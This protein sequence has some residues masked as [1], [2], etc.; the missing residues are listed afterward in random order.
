MLFVFLI[1]FS[2]KAVSSQE[3]FD[4]SLIAN[5]GNWC[6]L[7]HGGHDDC[8]N[9]GPCS[10]CSEENITPTHLCLEQCPPTDKLDLLCAIH[11]TCVAHFGFDTHCSY[12][13]IPGSPCACDCAFL[14][15]LEMEPCAPGQR[16]CK[17]Y[18]GVLKKLFCNKS[19]YDGAPNNRQCFKHTKDFQACKTMNTC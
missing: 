13:F 8:C 16:E 15:A 7:H 9:G 3:T 6:G 17:S 10:S 12:F 1:L 5:Y 4:E 14:A 18:V 11:D 19:C 2:C